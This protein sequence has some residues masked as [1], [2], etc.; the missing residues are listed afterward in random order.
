MTLFS[1]LIAGAA[2]ALATPNAGQDHSGHASASPGTSHAALSGAHAGF[3]AQQAEELRAG[4]GLG[5]AQAAERNGYPGPRHVL[6][7]AR[8]LQLTPAQEQKARDLFEA[9]RAEAIPLGETLIAQE[10]ALDRLFATRMIDE[11]KL[12][13]ATRAVGLTTA[14]LRAVHLRY[15]LTMKSAMTSDQVRRYV[16]LRGGA[17]R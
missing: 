15:H 4:A 1:Y 13:E 17:H 16:E 10:A 9:M 12:A 11:S 2:A 14:A 8:A 5:F 7:H 6:E 3:S